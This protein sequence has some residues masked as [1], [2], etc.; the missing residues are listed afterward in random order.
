[1]S[2]WK[3]VFT[4]DVLVNAGFWLSV[5][6]GNE[7]L[8][9]FDTFIIPTGLIGT[10]GLAMYAFGLA[11]M[12][13]LFWRCFL[14]LFI[15]SGAW[16]I[17]QAAREPDFDTGTAIGIAAAVLLVGLTSVAIYRLGGSAWVGVLGI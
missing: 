9:A 4:V 3:I 1:M 15:A 14:P 16:D 17:T 12:P 13:Q 7:R 2:F 5:W 10:V 8:N 6:K 11:T